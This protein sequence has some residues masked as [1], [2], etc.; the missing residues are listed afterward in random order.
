[1]RYM[2]IIESELK[3]CAVKRYLPLMKIGCRLFD[4][5][6]LFSLI[7]HRKNNITSNLRETEMLD[8]DQDGF[9]IM[10][11]RQVSWKWARPCITGPPA[12]LLK[13]TVSFLDEKLALWSKT[14]VVHEANIGEI[15]LCV[16]SGPLTRLVKVFSDASWDDR[17]YTGD[18]KTEIS[19]DLLVDAEWSINDHL[20]PI[21]A[22]YGSSSG[23]LSLLSSDLRN[24]TARLGGI[25]V[26]IPHPVY[27]FTSCGLADVI[28][29]V[30][31]GTILV[32]SQLPDDFLTGNITASDGMTT[33]FPNDEQDFSCKRS[34]TWSSDI[35][36]KFRMQVTLV[37]FS[38]KA[39]PMPS[40]SGNNSYL[41]APTKI[42]TMFSLQHRHDIESR[43]TSGSKFNQLMLVSI[44]I[45]RFES[46]LVIEKALSVAS[47]IN[48]HVTAIARHA[49]V[50]AIIRSN[51]D[52]VQVAKRVNDDT[53]DTVSIVCIHM[54]EVV[55]TLASNMSDSDD[56]INLLCLR[57][58]RIEFGMEFA[59]NMDANNTLSVYKC[60]VQSC[61]LQ[62]TGI[63][64]K[65]VDFLKIGTTS[66]EKLHTQEGSQNNIMMRSCH[67]SNS[68]TSS[69]STGTSTLAVDLMSPLIITLDVDLMKAVIDNAIEAFS[70]PV[71]FYSKASVD[72]DTY[73]VSTQPM[74]IALLSL[75]V[76]IS[77]SFDNTEKQKP[78][79]REMSNS[80]F[81]RVILSHVFVE[82]PKT[83]TTENNAKF[84]LTLE[85][86]DFVVGL[87]GSMSALN[88]L[89]QHCGHDT[90]WMNIVGSIRSPD[91]FYA[92]KSKQS[93]ISIDDCK[94]VLMPTFLIDYCSTTGDGVTKDL[95]DTSLTL[96][97]L[98]SHISMKLYFMIPSSSSKSRFVSSVREIH[99]TIGYHYSRIVRLLYS[100]EDV[101]DKLRLALFAKERERL[102]M[103]A[104]APSVCGWLRVSEGS[105]L[106]FHRLFST[107]LLVRYWVVMS[108]SLLVSVPTLC[109][110]YV[111]Q[112][113]MIL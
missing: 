39:V 68:L 15:E 72:G 58:T 7:S 57:M 76:E 33:N 48:Y 64:H 104:L 6:D 41:I 23:K 32:T 108:N 71:Q 82:I 29:S 34:H 28:C 36:A 83:G 112:T 98:M 110:C 21:P 19:S 13:S 43:D 38:V 78:L 75:I 87:S 22:W 95:I 51:R 84:L 3:E 88:L 94:K 89:K 45:P 101:V 90:Q 26:S 37:D 67:S 44:L 49:Q 109:P 35:T 9:P 79:H 53:I 18:W 46:N 2:H 24:V 20:Q 40:G 61:M 107:A 70:V 8:D 11:K 10:E 63:D 85:D 56:E 50:G 102:G 55:L 65:L 113:S 17:W 5:R 106:S 81:T 62:M 103:I 4:G 42:T 27:S 99:N 92:F 12:L 100:S 31:S 86:I 74:M 16:D 59:C 60:I 105:D 14:F 54:S 80:E 97:R 91:S 96:A 111:L 69:D 66:D 77:E 25:R 93:L 73:D 30:A 47:T 1:M 52:D